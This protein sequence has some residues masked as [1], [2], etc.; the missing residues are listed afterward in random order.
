MID[1]AN[2]ELLTFDCYGTLIDWESGIY[3]AAN[4]ILTDHDLSLKRDDIL[5]RYARAEAAIE[6]DNYR[7]YRAVLSDAVA[8]LAK[9]LGVTLSQSGC[10]QFALSIAD[11]PPFDDTVEALALLKSRFKLGIISNIDR[12]LFA[13]SAN[14][15]KIDF[16]YIVTA[17]DS[18]FYKP[19]KRMFDF[20]QNEMGIDRTKT[21]HVAQ[22]LYHDIV[23]ANKIGLK[24]VWINRRH[25]QPGSGATPKAAARPDMEFSDLISFARQIS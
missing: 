3:E 22:S 18:H 4:E 16:D 11:W 24:A 7:P 9:E 2:I 14:H 17:Q 6:S 8:Y 20:A 12:D 10:E 5:E 25:G 21:V 1:F 15:L 19:D 23:V 13:L